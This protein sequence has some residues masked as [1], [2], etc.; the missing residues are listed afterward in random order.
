MHKKYGDGFVAL[1]VA[2][3]NPKDEKIRA[4][5][6]AFLQKQQASFT[7]LIAEGDIDDWYSRLKIGSIPCVFIFDRENRRA[8]KLVEDQIEDKAIDAEVERLLKK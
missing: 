3:D 1:S 5:I 8:K 4:R 6:D 7:N 2:L